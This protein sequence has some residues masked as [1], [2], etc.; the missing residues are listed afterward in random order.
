MKKFVT[1]LLALVMVLSCA[2]F[3]VAEEP[4]KLTLMGSRNTAVMLPF[5]EHLGFKYMEELLGIDFE[6]IDIPSS[7]WN[8][9]FNLTLTGG[10]LPDMFTKCSISKEVARDNIDA[11]V[12]IDL[13]QYAEYI[14]NYMALLESDPDLKALVTYEDG[15]IGGFAQEA[16]YGSAESKLMPTNVGLIYTPWL[17]V[18]DMEMPKTTEDL[19]LFLKA[20]KEKDPNGNGKADEIGLSPVYGQSGLKL[21]AN[22]FGLPFDTASNM[23]G[24]TEDG[25]AWFL[26]DNENYKAF[27]KYFNKLWE[28][29]LLDA[30]LFTQNQQQVAAKGQS[31]PQIMAVSAHGSPS[32]V[33]TSERMWLWDTLPLLSSEVSEGVWTRRPAGYFYTGVVTTACKNIPKA[34]EFFDYFYSEEGAQLGWGGIEGVTWAWNEDGTS[35]EFLFTEEYPDATAIRGAYAFQAGG[36][37][38]SGYPLKMWTS[39]ADSA[40]R[41]FLL[42]NGEFAAEYADQ[43]ALRYP[44]VT[45]DARSQAELATLATDIT[46]YVDQTMAQFITGELD[47]DAEWDNYLAT[48]KA[49]RLDDMLAIMQKG[50]DNL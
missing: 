39:T 27:L 19:Y 33:A 8:E 3:A 21:M 7:S 26:A 30:E 14:P 12:F 16:N 48:L 29:G 1:L 36:G 37:V 28:E 46:S 24:Y 47:I 4:V 17:E 18:L 35:W 31:D 43:F 23:C 41:W 34:L 49:M 11:G 44:A 38:A 20:V 22:W 45:Y 50:L 42:K 13:A 6:F 10:D 15:V 9:Q 32:S 2:S 40:E 25:K 5:E